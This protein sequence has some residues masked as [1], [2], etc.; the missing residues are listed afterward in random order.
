MKAEHRH[1][2]GTNELADW[3]GN[4]PDYLKKNIRPIIGIALILFGLA[5]WMFQKTQK[6]NSETKNQTELSAR[7]MGLDQAKLSILYAKSQGGDNSPVLFQIAQLLEQEIEKAKGNENLT[8]ITLIKNAQALRA[9]LHYQPRIVENQDI[10][11]QVKQ[12]QNLYQRAADA[13]ADNQTLK[14]MAE[15][16]LGL[17]AEELGDFAVA[18]QIY[19]D[20]TQNEDYAPTVSAHQAQIRLEIMADYKTNV[21]FA[22]APP[23]PLLDESSVFDIPGAEGIPFADT[24]V[25]IPPMTDINSTM[26]ANK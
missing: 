1:E 18:K 24:V 11:F 13:A 17:C 10:D 16:G 15:F 7:I 19:T 4:L 3:I 22:K 20:L 8:A 23:K 6:T 14:A 2:L 21:K 5:F 26:D 9:D 12:A 25:D